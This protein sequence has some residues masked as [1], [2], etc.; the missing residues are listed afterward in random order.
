MNDFE[1]K[2]GAE[3]FGVGHFGLQAMVII[4]LRPICPATK[5]VTYFLGVK[6]KKIFEKPY[7]KTADSKKLSFSK[8][9]GAYVSYMVGFMP[10]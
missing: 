2:L 6:Q 10:N 5:F 8:Q 1:F 3:M 4:K 7:P 9:I